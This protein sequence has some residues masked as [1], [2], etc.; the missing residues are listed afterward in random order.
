M[1]R[2]LV[3][4]RFRKT[5]KKTE[6][7]RFLVEYGHF[8]E[9]PNSGDPHSKN[10]KHAVWVNTKSHSL[11]PNETVL[12][13][14]RIRITDTPSGEIIGFFSSVK[15][16][17][18]ELNR[19]YGRA[20]IKVTRLSTMKVLFLDIDGVLNTYPIG[21]KH[22]RLNP[23]LVAKLKDSVEKHNAVIVLTSS[24]RQYDFPARTFKSLSDAGWSNPPIIGKTKRM[25]NRGEEILQWLSENPITNSYIVLDDELDSLVPPITNIVQSDRSIGITDK[26]I[27]RM[28]EIWKAV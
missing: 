7:L 28:D 19:F 8:V 26:E 25:D 15:D 5:T 16:Y 12:E 23:A 1:K 3:V 24:W 10:F 9:I 22:W 27:A 21:K 17:I 4:E 14:A 18:E 2:L 13:S 11:Q 20:N 6:I